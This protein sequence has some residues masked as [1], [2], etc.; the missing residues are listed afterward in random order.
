MAPT[1][2]QVQE[3]VEGS[4][5]GKAGMKQYSRPGINAIFLGPPG[6]G[7]GTQAQNVKDH[8]GVCQLATGDMLRAEV[9]SGSE[10][11]QE[12]KQVMDSGKLVADELV[13][14]LIESNLGTPQCARGFLLD[15]FPRTVVQA[16]KLDQVLLR[17]KQEIDSVIEFDIDDKLLVSRITG[18]LMHP[19]SGRTYHE[20]FHPPKRPMTDDVSGEPLIRRSDDTAEALTKRLA[21]YHDQ[22]KPLSKYYSDQKVL[23]VV[24]ASQKPAQVWS[25]IDSAL[26]KAKVRAHK[27]F[28]TW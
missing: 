8:Y 21:A 18:R 9:A 4:P 5:T 24:D 26:Q 15:G 13:V 7:K 14:K 16:Q 22:T 11:G 17:R 23:A 25:T 27:A 1:S 12:V 3:K 6:A 20:E 10:L 28:F 2:V 19:A